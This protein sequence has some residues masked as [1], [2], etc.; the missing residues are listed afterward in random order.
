MVSPVRIG[1]DYSFQ[2]DLNRIDLDIFYSFENCEPDKNNC[3][4]A[5]S[6]KP[7]VVVVK[8]LD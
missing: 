6:N 5:Y 1:I 8:A 7:K 3:V 4:R 2:E